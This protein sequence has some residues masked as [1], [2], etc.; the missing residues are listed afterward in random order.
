MS[1]SNFNI[2][3]VVVDPTSQEISSLE[4]NGKAVETGP[5][6][7]LQDNRRETINVGTY[8][9][10][11]VI[12]P[13]KGYDAMEKATITLSN[14]PAGA[15]LHE[16]I[17]LTNNTCIYSFVRKPGV[18]DIV[19]YIHEG[20]LHDTSGAEYDEDND[21]LTLSDETYDWTRFID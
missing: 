6:V 13:S 17:D 14:I 16:W 9:V 1:N 11:V 4:V 5:V 19:L 18:A 15:G 12:T 7:E 21:T 8:T 3:K 20:A 2:T 10:P